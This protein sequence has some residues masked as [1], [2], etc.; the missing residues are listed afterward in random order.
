M[1]FNLSKHVLLLNNSFEPI[2]IVNGKKAIIMLL[3]DKVDS[4]EKSSIKIKSEKLIVFLPR[5]IKLKSYVHI[6][7]RQISLTRK[8]IFDRDNHECQYCGNQKYPLTL[9]HIIPKQKGGNDTWENLVAA[10]SRCN[11]K[12]GNRLLNET[13]MKLLQKP[14]KPNYILYL[15]KYVKQEY[16]IWKPYLY[17]DKN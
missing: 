6:K 8:N 2:T 14:V 4:V 17:M 10:C 12:K 1:S 15:Q 11:I 7:K 13:N 16:K 3:L 5:V 9:D